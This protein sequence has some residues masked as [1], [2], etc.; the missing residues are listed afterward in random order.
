MSVLLSSSLTIAIKSLK[1]PNLRINTEQHP[2]PPRAPLDAFPKL[3]DSFLSK[4]FFAKHFIL[5]PHPITMAAQKRV[6]L[7]SAACVRLVGLHSG[8]RVDNG[9]GLHIGGMK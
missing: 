1:L 4:I 5:D 7:H 9:C 2:I 6:W 8:A 3:S